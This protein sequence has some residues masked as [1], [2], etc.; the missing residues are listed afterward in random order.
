[1]TSV[2]VVSTLRAHWGSWWGPSPSRT[3]LSCWVKWVQRF[4]Q[5]LCPRLL[6]LHV[7]SPDL[8]YHFSYQCFSVC[9][10]QP[11][12]S[13]AQRHGQRCQVT[14]PGKLVITVRCI[15]TTAGFYFYNPTAEK[16]RNNQRTQP[17]WWLKLLTH[18]F[19]LKLIINSLHFHATWCGIWI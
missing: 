9:D 5:A 8:V 2:A 7:V 14:L 1:M 16:D 4:F 13:V 3:T 10:S 12:C 17:L 19:S 11:V 6:T 15:S 18:S